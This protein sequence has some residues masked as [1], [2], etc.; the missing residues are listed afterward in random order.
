VRRRAIHHRGFTLIEAVAVIVVLSVAFPPMLWA[1]RR[2]HD[3]RVF[4]ARMATAR[5]LAAEKL[6][7]LISDRHS[8]NRGYTWLTAGHY[9]AEAS[10][11]GFPGFSRSVAL[12][13]T[14]PSLTGGG[15]GYMKATVTVSFTDSGGASRSF[16]L[17]TVVTR[18]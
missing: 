8:L 6:E 10:I 17:S 15:V 14:G 16:A 12:V 4:P 11:T 13:E 18:Y 3:A 9:P 2:E 5:W 1:I 7:D